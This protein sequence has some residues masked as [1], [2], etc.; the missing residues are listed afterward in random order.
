VKGYWRFLESPGRGLFP[1][2]LRHVSGRIDN[3]QI[4]LQPEQ[5]VVSP[6]FRLQLTL[7]LHAW[8]SVQ[9]KKCLP[10]ESTGTVYSYN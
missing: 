5:P 4:K 6:E 9:T 7:L 2:I 3:D 8:V 10:Q 1:V